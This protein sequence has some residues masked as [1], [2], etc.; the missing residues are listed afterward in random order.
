M[1]SEWNSCCLQVS[2][3]LHLKG[4]VTHCDM[5]S[6]EMDD[7][8]RDQQRKQSEQMLT[9]S[10]TEVDCERLVELADAVDRDVSELKRVQLYER[11]SWENKTQSQFEN[12]GNLV[13]ATRNNREGMEVFHV[14]W[15]P[16][17]FFW[18]LLVLFIV[19]D[20]VIVCCCCGGGGGACSR[21]HVLLRHG[22][23][24]VFVWRSCCPF[25]R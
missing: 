15:C 22:L 13:E 25:S 3:G 1:L 4:L 17:F 2:L 18:L 19:V 14:P 10:E 8:R 11:E 21:V 7:L 9:H 16:F 24:R 23:L 12:F 6:V 20:V 5:L